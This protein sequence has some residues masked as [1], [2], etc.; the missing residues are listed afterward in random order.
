MA[1]RRHVNTSDAIAHVPIAYNYFEGHYTLGFKARMN[2]AV[3]PGFPRRC[4]PERECQRIIWQNFLEKPNRGGGER[5]KFYDVDPSP[6]SPYLLALSP[7]LQRL[8]SSW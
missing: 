6:R 3:D 2:P 1:S 4:K 7:L 5:Q 8:P